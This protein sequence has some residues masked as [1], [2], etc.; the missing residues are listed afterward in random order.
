MI[1]FAIK[2]NSNL[3]YKIKTANELWMRNSKFTATLLITIL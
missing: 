3:N 1:R 2:I